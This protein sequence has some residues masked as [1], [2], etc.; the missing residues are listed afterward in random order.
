MFINKTLIA[1]IAVAYHSTNAIDL[2]LEQAID[3]NATEREQMGYFGS[4]TY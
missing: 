2:S 1:A 4:I 3:D